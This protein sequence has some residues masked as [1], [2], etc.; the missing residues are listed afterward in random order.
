MKVTKKGSSDNSYSVDMVRLRVKVF[1]ENIQTFFNAYMTDSNVDYWESTQYTKY[2]HNWLFKYMD[3]FNK[4]CSFYVGYNFNSEQ[5]SLKHWLVIEYNPNK[6]DITYGYLNKILKQFFSDITKVEIVSVD[7]ACDMPVNITDIFCD[8][9]GKKVKKIFNYG[10]D[11]K[12]IYLGQGDGRIK[13]YNKRHEILENE[14][15][16]IGHDLTRYEVTVSSFEHFAI[17][18][19]LCF[20][21]AEYLNLAPIYCVSSYQVDMMLNGTERALIYAVLNG[22]PIEELPRKNKE[23]VKKILSESAGNTIESLGFA[24]AFTKYFKYHMSII[25]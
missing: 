23:K 24:Q 22:Y 6:N 12:T 15:R 7:L 5:K 10:G 13:I 17:C 16:D 9:G 1:S 25:R 19:A 18:K 3:V 11:D 8:K 20:N 2:R 14:K 4:E 21:I